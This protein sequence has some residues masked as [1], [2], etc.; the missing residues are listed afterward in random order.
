[1]NRNI[2]LA[3]KEL[4]EF[5]KGV[6]SG[7]SFFFNLSVPLFSWRKRAGT[8][9]DWLP[10]DVVGAIGVNGWLTQAHLS[11]IPRHLLV[12]R[13]CCAAQIRGIPV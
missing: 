1:M 7:K 3:E 2:R 8:V 13:L 5:V 12:W 10:L 11:N 9:L 4:I 6:N